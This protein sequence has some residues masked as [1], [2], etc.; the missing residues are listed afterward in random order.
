MATY[1]HYAVTT[2]IAVFTI[3]D[4][5]LHILLVQRGREPFKGQWALPGGFLRP[6]EDLD[7]CARRELEEET[8]VCGFYLE[9]LRTLGA[10]DR[11]PRERV[12]TVAYFAL[13]R[14]DQMELKPGS[15]A[16]GAAWK[17][18]KGLPRLAFDHD[19]IVEAARERLAGK[20]EYSTIAFQFL[21][22]RFTMREVHAIYESVSGR[23]IDRRN[24]YKKMLASGDLVETKE[25]RIEGA[26]R[27]A[28]V[29]RLRRPATVRITR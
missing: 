5:A 21:P 4:G 16:A 19:L 8:G 18:V 20:L 12:I 10:L 11:D 3:K 29:Y 25:K 14:S 24:F 22:E 1:P 28:M 26:H 13:I 9:Q 6:D 7:R 2:D 27:P 15:D 23:P 17:R